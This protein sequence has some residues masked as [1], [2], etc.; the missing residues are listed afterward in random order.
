MLTT[1]AGDVQ[2]ARALQ[3][4]AYGYLLKSTLSLELLATIRAVHRGRKALSP[5]ISFDLA[6]HAVEDALSPVEV[7]V[8]RLNRR[9]QFQQEDRRAALAH[10]RRRQGSGAE[11][12]RQA[13]RQRPRARGRAR[14][15]AR[16]HLSS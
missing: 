9:R 16:D 12:P 11:H 7:R 4:G 8:L 1:F 2:V 13:G 6:E 15:E 5:E 3:A 10:G 14:A